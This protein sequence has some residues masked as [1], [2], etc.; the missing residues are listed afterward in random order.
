MKGLQMYTLRNSMKTPEDFDNTLRRVHE[1]GYDNVQ[2]TPPAFTNAIEVAKQL[3]TYELKADSTICTLMKIPESIDD[4]ARNAEALDTDVLRTDSIV[5]DDRWTV[6]GYKRAAEH[7]NVCGKLAKEKGLRFMYHFHAFEFIKLGDTRGIDILLNET[8]PAT[9]MFQ[10]DVFWLTSAGTE[11][12]TSLRMFAGRAA[13]MHMKDYVIV[14]SGTEVLEVTKAASAPVGTGNL[15]WDKIIATAKEIGI[16]N[17]VAEDDMG[18]LDPFESA[19]QSVIGMKN[20][21]L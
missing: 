3:K 9:V 14:P 8:D 17:F 4:I 16:Y 5:K 2:I 11:A 13:Y 15:N 21:G 1:M 20:L 10:P 18:I 7:L 6:E 12:S 19:A